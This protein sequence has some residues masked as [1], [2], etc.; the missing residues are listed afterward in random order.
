[1]DKRCMEKREHQVG[2]S[3]AQEEAKTMDKVKVEIRFEEGN[4]WIDG[5]LINARWKP[6]WNRLK[7]K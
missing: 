2:G 3:V 1:M 7:E 6:V 4:N 5:E